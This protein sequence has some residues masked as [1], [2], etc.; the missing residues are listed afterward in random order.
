MGGAS[1]GRGC[2][3]AVCGGED[4]AGLTCELRDTGLTE[5]SIRL[6]TQRGQQVTPCQLI[7]SLFI[8]CIRSFANLICHRQPT[9]QTSERCGLLFPQCSVSPFSLEALTHAIQLPSSSQP[10]R[11]LLTT[12]SSSGKTSAGHSRLYICLS[13]GYQLLLSLPSKKGLTCIAQAGLGFSR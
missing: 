8:G 3:T 1:T 7:T 2:R 12:S 10:S 5:G 4:S 9:P 13:S 11:L 6:L